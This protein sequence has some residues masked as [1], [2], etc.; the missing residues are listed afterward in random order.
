MDDKAFEAFVTTN[1]VRME[2]PTLQGIADHLRDLIA[3]K[4]SGR[5]PGLKIGSPVEAVDL[6]YN[7]Y[8]YGEVSRM[9]E[10]G[11]IINTAGDYE[12]RIRFDKFA[13]RILPDSEWSWIERS[14]K[15][16]HEKIEQEIADE[17]EA[18][19]ADLE[20]AIRDRDESK[21]KRFPVAFADGGVVEIYCGAYLHAYRTDWEHHIYGVVISWTP[22]SCFVRTSL[23]VFDDKITFAKC[24]RAEILTDEH[25]VKVD[26]ELLRRHDEIVEAKNAGKTEV[27]SM[28][29][30]RYEGAEI[31][32]T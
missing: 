22:K 17:A 16:R 28:L 20:E 18:A 9:T 4:R 12:Q 29:E 19:K 3:Q 7:I 5:P 32:I 21:K 2:L 14:L 1:A 23:T 27:A 8:A 30:Q 15:E 24:A 6:R 11:C 10:K 25:W 13:V 31:S 26:A